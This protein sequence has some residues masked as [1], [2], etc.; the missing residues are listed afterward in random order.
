MSKFF[1]RLSKT[2]TFSS[3]G[4]IVQDSVVSG[5]DDVIAFGETAWMNISIL[6]LRQEVEKQEVIFLMIIERF[7]HKFDWTFIDQLYALYTHSW[8]KDPVYENINKTMQV[9]P[10]YG[11]IINRAALRHISLEEALIEEGKFLFYRND[12]VNYLINYGQDHFSRIISDNP[13]WMEHVRGK[14]IQKGIP[15]KEM[16]RLDAEYMWEQKLKKF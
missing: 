16:I 15:L 5:G 1:C 10:W 2:F 8:L 12:T 6:N 11:D 4:V 14:A 7:P 9:G 3:T 13:V